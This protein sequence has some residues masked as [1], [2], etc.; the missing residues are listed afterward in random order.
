MV[1]TYN[2]RSCRISLGWWWSGGGL[3]DGE[4]FGIIEGLIIE[5][6]ETL[7]H[8]MKVLLLKLICLLSHPLD[9]FSLG[10]HVHEVTWIIIDHGAEVS[11]QSILLTDGDGNYLW[12]FFLYH[13]S[14][15]KLKWPNIEWWWRWLCNILNTWWFIRSLHLLRW[16]C[17][18]GTVHL[19]L[20]RLRNGVMVVE[21]SWWISEIIEVELRM[22]VLLHWIEA[23]LWLELIKIEKVLVPIIMGDHISKHII[24]H[25][26]LCLTWTDLITFPIIVLL[27]E[28]G[29]EVLVVPGD[30][31]AVPLFAWS[32]TERGYLIVWWFTRSQVFVLHIIYMKNIMCN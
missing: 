20:G 4:S 16:W 9:P 24:K 1:I 30:R 19:R 14:I 21:W 12:F 22:H 31:A 32:S 3:P 2:I 17:V 23:S 5:A 26:S 28:G 8:I 15:I 7:L 27:D 10:H 18:G 29:D 25:K 11:L 6:A 13:L